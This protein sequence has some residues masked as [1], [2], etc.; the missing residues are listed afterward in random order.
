MA[1][2]IFMTNLTWATQA[3]NAAV[4]GTNTMNIQGTTATQ[5]VDIDECLISGLATASTIGNFTVVPMSTM[6]AT[7]AA[8]VAPNSDGV[9]QSNA[10]PVVQNT[11]ISATTQPI[12]SNA[13]TAPHLNLS[14]N[15]FG[16]IVRWNAAPTQQFTM[17]GNAVFAAGPPST[18]GGA[19]LLNLSTSGASTPAQAH[20]IYEP[21]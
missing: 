21:Y 14:I 4:A 19:I 20:I 9:M 17:I 16:G 11:Y 6:G 10:T 3:L 1:K 18:F 5:I 7:F 13:V 12:P 15:T 2:R 8:L